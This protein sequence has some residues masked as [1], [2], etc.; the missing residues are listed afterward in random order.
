MPNLVRYLTAKGVELVVKGILTF[1]L[2][3]PK[4]LKLTVSLGL[5]L[6]TAGRIGDATKPF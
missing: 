3:S 1:T 6:L 4:G 5:V 2:D